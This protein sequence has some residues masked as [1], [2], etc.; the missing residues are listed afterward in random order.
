MYLYLVK[1][2]GIK[3]IKIGITS[4]FSQRSVR[5]KSDF[6]PIDEYK[7]FPSPK[8]KF[9]EKELHSYFRKHKTPLEFGNGK[10]EFFNVDF[11]RCQDFLAGRLSYP[12]TISD[13]VLEEIFSELYRLDKYRAVTKLEKFLTK[14]CIL[15]PLLRSILASDEVYNSFSE[16]SQETILKFII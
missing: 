4:D 10:T 3:P 8:A 9:L 14:Q 16:L 13:I 12:E 1:F 11:Q 2:R 15:H 7:L 5:L 6:G